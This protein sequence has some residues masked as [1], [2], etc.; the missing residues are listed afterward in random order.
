M[1]AP[2]PA[3]RDV[4][5]RSLRERVIQT[6]SYEL[7]ALLLVAP[8]YQW[9]FDASTGESLQLLVTLS[10]AVMLW[11][12]IHNTLFDW[13]DARWFGRV[14]SDRRGWS[15]W[16]H[17]FSHEISTLFVTLPLIMWIGGH[18]FL[19]ALLIDLGLTLFYT[20]Y[21]WA[22]HCCFDRLRPVRSSQ[23]P[24]PTARRLP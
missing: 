10:V 16:A 11:S 13:L 6:L 23:S 17:A 1:E 15:R 21:A 3:E 4:P 24:R 20:A 19:D 2:M 9:L 7:G 22:F 8:L 12:P 5:L 14:A 18:R